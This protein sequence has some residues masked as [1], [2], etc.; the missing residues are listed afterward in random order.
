[1]P[2]HADPVATP[3]ASRPARSG[4][5]GRPPLDTE[6]RRNRILDAAS[7]LFIANGFTDTTVEAV[8]RA[9]GVTKRTMY[10]LVGDKTALFRAVCSH[11]HHNIGEIRLDL[12]ISNESLRANLNALALLLIEH[13]LA[14]DTVAI[15]RMVI[16]EHARFPDL[17]RD[18]NRTTR[19]DLN[20]KLAVVFDKLVELGMI[21]PV[22]SFQASEIFFDI[23][24][25]NLGFRKTLGFEEALPTREETELR[26][27]IFI[28]GY[29]RRNGLVEI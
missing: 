13:S 17:L 26:V 23:V 25:G 20:A 2:G 9:A 12:P 27:E 10:E 1:M 6:V 4:R 19:I 3:A 7:K 28:E 24:V 14:H 15:E 16:I 18:A 22:D 29:L 5:R 21:A 8:C 11:C